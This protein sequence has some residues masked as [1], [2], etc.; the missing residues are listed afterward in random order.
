MA[1]MKRVRSVKRV[2]SAVGICLSLATCG[3]DGQEKCSLLDGT[4]LQKTYQECV[5]S[6]GE[7]TPAAN[8]QLAFCT[9]RL[10]AGGPRFQPCRTVG[11]YWYTWDCFCPGNYS[12][13]E[14]CLLFY[15]ENAC[16]TT[17]RPDKLSISTPICHCS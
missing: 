9:L 8:G 3:G 1:S 6:G 2:A 7:V 11:G 10:D 16:S 4:D 12:G 5:A 14:V 17:A 13:G 15:P